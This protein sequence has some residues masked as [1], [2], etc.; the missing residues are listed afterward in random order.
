M[1]T[2]DGSLGVSIISLAGEGAGHEPDPEETFPLPP[3]G[4]IFIALQYQI[5]N[6][7]EIS[8]STWRL[9]LQGLL[10]SSAHNNQTNQDDGDDGTNDSNHMINLLFL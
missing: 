4:D 5:V 8:V 7:M 3:A 9:K 1:R 2:L 10:R 6:E